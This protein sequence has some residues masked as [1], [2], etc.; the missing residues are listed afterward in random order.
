MKKIKDFEKVE[1]AKDF[2]QIEPGPKLVK[3]VEVNDIEEK[4]YLEIKVDIASGELKGDFN[5]RKEQFGDWPQQGILRRSYKPQALP[6][7]KRFVVAV[8]KS[9]DGFK[10]DFDEQ[11]LV[12]K[13]FI[14][15]FGIEEYDNGEEIKE[16]IKIQEARSIQSYKEGKIQIPKPKTLPQKDHEKYISNTNHKTNDP[17]SLSGMDIDSEDLPF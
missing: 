10:F 17:D 4:E 5:R 1:E 13:L 12:G 6:F 16:S 8:E 15:N 14:A 3:I 11:K 2:K 9:N 7:F